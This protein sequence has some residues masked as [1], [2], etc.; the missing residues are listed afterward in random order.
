MVWVDYAILAIIGLSTVISL[1]R[2]FVKEAISLIVW[3]TAF[4]VASHYYPYLAPFFSN[5]ENLLIRN[6]VAIGLLFIS[7]LLLGG[8]IN[9]L[10]GKL[11]H[12]TG[13]S[14]TDRLLGVLFGALRGVLVVSA[15]LFF[16]DAFTPSAGSEWWKASVLIPEFD[17]IIEWFFS[18]LKDNSSFMQ[19]ASVLT[20]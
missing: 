7:A 5:I 19:Q 14:G 13:L 2:G 15:M 16:L 17:F 1:V 8:L 11:V 20:R 10:V 12:S 6:A 18:Y 3:I 4:F 9:Y